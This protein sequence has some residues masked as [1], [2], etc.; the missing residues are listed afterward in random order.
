[1]PKRIITLE[2]LIE[3]LDTEIAR[4]GTMTKWCDAH[5]LSLQ[6]ISMVRHGD[7]SPSA[8]VCQALGYRPVTTTTY[9]RIG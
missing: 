6:F 3:Y 9:E 5:G 2:E 4:A 7:R 8:T 1:M